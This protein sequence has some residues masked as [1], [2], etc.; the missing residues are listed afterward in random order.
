[1]IILHTGIFFIALILILFSFCGY[2]HLIKTEN[3]K[4][5]LEEVFLGSIIIT[6]F[7]TLIHFFTKITLTI[8]VLILI[9]GLI[10][11]LIKNN[12]KKKYIKFIFYFFLTLIFLSPI[13][14]NQKYHEDLG[15][16]HLPYIIGLVENKIIF[17]FANSNIAYNHNS[18][19]LNI[20]SLFY[21]SKNNFNFINLPSFL[22]YS[23]FI[24]FY[25]RENLNAKKIFISN[26]FIIISLFY[27]IIKFTRISEYGNDLPASIFSIL[28]I[29]YFL[30]FSETEMLKNK[31]NN[32]FFCFSFAIF[33]I[34]IKLSVLPILL[35][36]LFLLLKNFKIIRNEIFKLNSLFIYLLVI[37]F[38]VQQFIYTSCFIFPSN[39]TCI[40]TAWYNQDNLILREKLELINKSY[41]ASK[42]EFSK[43][44]YLE[45]FNWVSNWFNRN[46]LEIIE[47]FLTIAFPSILL[48]FLF[49]KTKNQSLISFEN[50]SFF[51]FFIILSFLFWLN[52]SPVYRFAVPYFLSLFFIFSINFYL[53][54]D[55]SKKIFLLLISISLIFSFSK[56]ILRLKN[57]KELFFGIEKINNKFY[58]DKKSNNKFV[59][60]YR[61]DIDSNKN[62]WQGRL[63]W[64]IPFLCSYNHLNVD[65]KYGYLILSK[66]KK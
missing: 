39:F 63:C 31:L 15:Y 47:H 23:F 18:I 60:I 27:L 16:Y 11:F 17:G 21:V 32:Y 12:N 30:K 46:Y 62:G 35:L 4:N 5:F 38:F 29:Y 51:I 24:I 36:P 28:S 57:Q 52:F 19:W 55:F 6:F 25:I 64:N 42:S 40:E 50:K 37:I 66:L 44:E 1:M 26:Y 3:E 10:I 56:N 9:L 59:N 41:Y 2:G 7:I 22:I 54:R 14:L 48:I 43:T 20:M 65:K 33:S 13:F 61:P 49:S 8:S 34:L 45:N 58:K 53:K